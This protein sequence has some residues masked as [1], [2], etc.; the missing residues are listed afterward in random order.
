MRSED[1]RGRSGGGSDTRYGRNEYGSFAEAAAVEPSMA[2]VTD[3]RTVQ[4][5]ELPEVRD[6]L[7]DEILSIPVE[8]EHRFTD[9]GETRAA[10]VHR[11]E[12]PPCGYERETRLGLLDDID[13]ELQAELDPERQTVAD[14][15][16][17]GTIVEFCEA[18]FPELAARDT[19][20]SD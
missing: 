5:G 16:E 18:C 3:I 11:S 7:G 19:E 15:V 12:T 1:T 6:R 10:L 17:R 20:S 2:H 9:T 8:H 14:V 4:P 13:D